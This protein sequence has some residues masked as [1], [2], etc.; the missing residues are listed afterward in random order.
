[1]VTYGRGAR[2]ARLILITLLGLVLA[3]CAAARHRDRTELAQ[4]GRDAATQR[5]P[6]WRF[7]DVTDAVREWAKSRKEDPTVAYGD[8]DDD[9][10]DD[11][12]LLV[13]PLAKS[14]SLKIVACLSSLGPTRPVVVEK[15]YCHDGITTVSKGGPYYDFGSD[16]EGTYPKDG[17]HA[18]CFEKAG[19][20]YVL[21]GD[22]FRQIVDSD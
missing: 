12:A 19:A 5:W 2:M 11:V 1:M 8:F 9:G 7:P 10:K 17:I 18:Y 4:L 21:E 13:Q 3:G 22:S 14:A 15:P 16:S 20:T 6:Q